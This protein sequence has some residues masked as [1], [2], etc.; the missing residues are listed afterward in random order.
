MVRLY[1]SEP[2]EIE[3]GQR[4]FDIAIQGQ[5]VLRNFDIVKE[6]GVPNRPIVKEFRKIPV[7]KDLTLTLTPSNNAKTVEIICN[8]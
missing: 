4:V 5:E 7:S 3:P 6:A 1:F 8:P 2:D